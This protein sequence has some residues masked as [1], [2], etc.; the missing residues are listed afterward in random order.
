MIEEL[1]GIESVKKVTEKSAISKISYNFI[2][3]L[4]DIVC[5]L[6]GCLVLI[7]IALIVKISYMLSGD[8]NSIF[9][10]QKRIGK[11]GKEFRL[12][13]FRTMVP[14]ADKVLEEMFKK[15]KKLEKEYKIKMKLDKDPRI[16]KMGRILRGSSIDELPQMINILIGNMSLVGN[17]PY[18]PREKKDMGKYYDDIIKTKPALTGLWQV[19]G[20]SNTT[21][22]K[23]L[24]LEKYYS[25]NCNLLL[26][27]KIILNT[28]KVVVLRKGAK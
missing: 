2:K 1:E 6:I 12:F 3:R 5:S 18:L 9:Y 21:F 23:R 20:R 15:D 4:F 11:N 25:N 28:F 13:K 14:N 19:S 8:F 24:K 7:P 10:S 17:R 16:T 27:I 26:D 22:K